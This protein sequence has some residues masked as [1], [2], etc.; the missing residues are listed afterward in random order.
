M[1]SE[2]LTLFFIIVIVL[3]YI[4]DYGYL[5]KECFAY[6]MY[7]GTVSTYLTLSKFYR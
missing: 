2:E 6:L 7:I 3:D 5:L 4:A 1:G